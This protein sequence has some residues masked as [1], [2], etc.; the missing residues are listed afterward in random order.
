MLRCACSAGTALDPFGYTAERRQEQ[1]LIGEFEATIRDVA[2]R[3]DPDHRDTAARILEL[4]QT[5]KGF[6][7]VKDKSIERYRE[8]TRDLRA[9][10]EHKT[11]L[12]AA[13]V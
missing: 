1:G 6:G 3:L 8:R 13:H 2:R 5:I 10:M 9:E 7:P 4:P 11:P 12:E